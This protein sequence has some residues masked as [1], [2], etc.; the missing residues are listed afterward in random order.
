MD[1]VDEHRRVGDLLGEKMRLKDAEKRLAYS[2]TLSRRLGSRSLAPD[3]MEL[4]KKI[5]ASKKKT[6]KKKSKK[7][8]SKRKKTK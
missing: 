4:I 8:R 3:D 6:K 7:K 2:K 1:R 5:L